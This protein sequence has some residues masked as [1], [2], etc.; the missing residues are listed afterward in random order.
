MNVRDKLSSRSKEAIHQ[1]TAKLFS[2]IEIAGGI[3]IGYAIARA[4]T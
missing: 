1:L 2:G 4:L 3:I